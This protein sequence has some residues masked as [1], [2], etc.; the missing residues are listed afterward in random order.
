M[1]VEREFNAV[2]Q[3]CI[4]TYIDILGQNGYKIEKCDTT[5]VP[6]SAQPVH[7]PTPSVATSAPTTVVTSEPVHVPSPIQPETTVTSE[8]ALAPTP[9]QQPYTKVQRQKEKKKKEEIQQAGANMKD[10]LTVEN[11]RAWLAEGR[12]YAWIAREKIG[13]KQDLIGQFARLNNLHKVKKQQVS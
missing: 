10:L 2:K 5:R 7:V 13:C 6:Q 1:N 4:K 11:V 8:P 12:T 9:T 3:D